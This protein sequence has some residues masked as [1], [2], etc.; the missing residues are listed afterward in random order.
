MPGFNSEVLAVEI[1]YCI[2]CNELNYATTNGNGTF[3]RANMSNNHH[4]H[5]QYIFKAPNKYVPPICNVLTKLQAGAKIS[6]NEM[7]LFKLAIDLGELDS[8]FAKIKRPVP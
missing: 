1:G 6:G 3:E 8:E 2:D 4:N 7:I 5:D